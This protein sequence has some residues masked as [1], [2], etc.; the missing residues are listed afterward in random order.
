MSLS[1]LPPGVKKINGTKA[2]YTEGNREGGGKEGRKKRRRKG[3]VEGGKGRM[4]LFLTVKCQ[5]ANLEEMRK[6]ETHHLATTIEV[7]DLGGSVDARAFPWS[8][9]KD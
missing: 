2:Y 8:H 9:E 7:A 1:T 5:V 3:N 4:E 6:I